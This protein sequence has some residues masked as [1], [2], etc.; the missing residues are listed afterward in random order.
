MILIIGGAYQGK[1]EFAR[2]LKGTEVTVS[3]GRT[4]S[5]DLLAASDMITHFHEVIRRL[6]LEKREISAVI[7]EV[8]AKNPDITIVMDEIGYGVVPM[9]AEDREYRELVGH[10]GQLLARQAEAVY[11]VVCG[12]GTR[13]K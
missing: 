5:L 8:L 4:I 9:S 3:D 6:W 11:R 2:Q 13:I 12:I 1:L 10:T 7:E